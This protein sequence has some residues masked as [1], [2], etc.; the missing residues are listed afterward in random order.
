[1]ILRNKTFG[2][3]L[4]FITHAHAQERIST[5]PKDRLITVNKTTL[6]ELEAAIAPHIAEAKRTYPI[7]RKQ[8]LDGLLDK[9]LFLVTVRLHD[10]DG[11]Y[12]QVFIRVANIDKEKNL[13]TGQIGN[14]LGVV[15]T[16][17]KGQTIEFSEN[18][19]VDWTILK[20]D[21]TEEG[22][23]V[24]KFLDEYQKK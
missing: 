5:I 2:L 15:H 24:G 18:D 8:F 19:V 3:A 21:G 22:N 14:V 9:Q 16:F 1:M 11:K 10:P 20:E 17:Q 23:Y 4:F 13:I 7:A 6:S 12:E